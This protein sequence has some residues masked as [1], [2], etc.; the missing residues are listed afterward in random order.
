MC[1]I[2]FSHW[3]N[4]FCGRY[5]QIHTM[6]IS[7]FMQLSS[8]K[9][10][11]KFPFVILNVILYSKSI[12]TFYFVHVPYFPVII[13]CIVK[14]SHEKL[15]TL[16]IKLTKTENYW[17][18]RIQSADLWLRTLLSLWDLHVKLLKANLARLFFIHIILQVYKSDGIYKNITH[19]T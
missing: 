4:E 14:Y 17:I 18:F 9:N 6:K 2:D 1:V 19:S 12:G 7:L 3:S 11:L 13:S 8:K 10:V 5:T 16:I 15:Y